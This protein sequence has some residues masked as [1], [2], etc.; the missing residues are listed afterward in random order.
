S[1]RSLYLHTVATAMTDSLGIS[2][3][4]VIL[5]V[6]PMFHANAWGIPYTATMVGATQIYPAQFMQPCDLLQLFERERVT[7]TAGVPTIWI[8]I[9]CLLEKEKYD[10]SSLRTILIG[11]SAVPSSMIRYFDE[12]YGIPILQAWGMTETSPLGSICRLKSYMQSLG[13]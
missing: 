3:R 2:E 8:G 6:V 1:H 11:G 5:P 13:D 10:L 12:K 7:L 4:D 9:M